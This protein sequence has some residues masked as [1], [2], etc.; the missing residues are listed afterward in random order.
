MNFI[1]S[2]LKAKKCSRG[3]FISSGSHCSAE[4][5][6]LAGFEWVILDM[7]HGLGDESAILHQIEALQGYACAPLVRIPALRPEY[8][9][10][11]LDFGA[12]GIMAPMIANASEAELLVKYMRYPPEGIRGLTSGSRAASYGYS[13]KEYFAR[14]NSELLAI[15]QIETAAGVENANA[16]AAVDGIDI[17]FMGHSDLSMNLGKYNDYTSDI[18]ADAEQKVLAA[19]AKYG[20]MA[21]MVLRSSMSAENYVKRGFSFMAMGT[22]LGCLKNAFS[23]L[24]KKGETENKA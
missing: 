4:I 11:A 19:A 23:A 10:R 17:I 5:A 13:F 22:D 3:I 1:K 6:A 18:M 9:K 16:I 2:A 7:E 8:I 21:G 20:K 14:A 15:A 12:A 24:L